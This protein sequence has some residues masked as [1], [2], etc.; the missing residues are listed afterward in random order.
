MSANVGC[1]QLTLANMLAGVLVRRSNSLVWLNILIM[2]FR[3]EI[4]SDS[5]SCLLTYNPIPN[6]HAISNFSFNIINSIRLLINTFKHAGMCT[7]DHVPSRGSIF[8]SPFRK[9]FCSL[10]VSH[11][12]SI[13]KLILSPLSW[14][15]Q[16]SDVYFVTNIITSLKCT[17][18]RMLRRFLALSNLAT[19]MKRLSSLLC[20]VSLDIS[21]NPLYCFDS[22]KH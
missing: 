14:E 1:H 13:Y 11:R 5:D 10:N 22:G 16:W 7:V 19:R 3:P 15:N 8:P 17:A 21:F 18:F 4:H 2:H 20:C 12:S 6:D 9:L